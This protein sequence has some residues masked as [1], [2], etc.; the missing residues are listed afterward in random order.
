MVFVAHS[1]LAHK[2]QFLRLLFEKLRLLSTFFLILGPH[3]S[4]ELAFEIFV[5]AGQT[6]IH[7]NDDARGRER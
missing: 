5:H 1:A 3:G 6:C 4:N 7:V 2:R